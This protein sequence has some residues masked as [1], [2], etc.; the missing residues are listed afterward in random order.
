M[1]G[2][3]HSFVFVFKTRSMDKSLVWIPYSHIGQLL[4]STVILLFWMEC[5]HL[6]SSISRAIDFITTIASLQLYD[7]SIIF[8]YFTFCWKW[9]FNRLEI[10][11]HQFD[12]VNSII[13]SAPCA[14]QLNVGINYIVIESYQIFTTTY[15]SY[16]LQYYIQ[17]N[18][19]RSDTIHTYHYI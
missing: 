7:A 16:V 1:D 5:F 19:F 12:E 10:V 4:P 2:V 13:N 8:A 9:N 14:L 15:D 17:L 11:P 6:H 18:N 3:V